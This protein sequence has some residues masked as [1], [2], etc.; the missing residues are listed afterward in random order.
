VSP[1]VGQLVLV[2]PAPTRRRVV[3]G[4]G[5]GWTSRPADDG[6][7]DDDRQEHHQDEQGHD[8]HCGGLGRADLAEGPRAVE[9]LLG[10]VNRPV[11]GLVTEVEAGPAEGPAGDLL[12]PSAM[13]AVVP[14]A[15]GEVSRASS[16]K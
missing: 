13:V 2:A 9:V 11:I 3:G 10:E 15:L 6:G 12:G 14:S 8:R 4:Q 16:R 5:R 1:L 7:H